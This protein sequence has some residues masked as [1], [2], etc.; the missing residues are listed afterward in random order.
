MENTLAEKANPSWFW[1]DYIST[2]RFWGV[3]LAGFLITLTSTMSNSGIFRL[4][5]EQGYNYRAIAEVW[6]IANIL[7][8][9][10]VLY[11]LRKISNWL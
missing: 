10:V 1:Q 3:V 9:F 6:P 2:Y 8:I 4:F 11:F 7:A 5:S